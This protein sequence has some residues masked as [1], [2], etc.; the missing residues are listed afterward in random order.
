MKRT[1][2]FLTMLVL[3]VGNVA[4]A[5]TVFDDAVA[6]W[7]FEGTGSTVTDQSLTTAIDLQLS[8]GGIDAQSRESSARR[9]VHPTARTG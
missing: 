9:F 7:P 2:V 1:A 5:A 4:P 3:A 6:Y 8:D